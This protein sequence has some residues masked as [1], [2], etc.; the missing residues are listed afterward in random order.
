MS[1]GRDNTKKVIRRR[2]ILTLVLLSVYMVSMFAP[3]VASADT[4]GILIPVSQTFTN[5]GM[6]VEPTS[7]FEYRLAPELAWYPMPAYSEGAIYDFSLT[8]NDSTEIGPIDFS[9]V[10][11]GIYTYHVMCTSPLAPYYTLDQQVFT[12]MV[13]VMHGQI[14]IVVAYQENGNK[15]SDIRFDHEYDYGGD[16]IPVTTQDPPVKKTVSGDRPKTASLF[17]F[18]LRAEDT[19]NPMPAGSKDGVKLI[20]IEGTGQTEFGSWTYAEQGVYHYTIKELNTGVSGYT[21]DKT[22]Y[23]ITDTVTALSDGRLVIDRSITDDT[24]R[25]ATDFSFVNV[26]EAPILPNPFNPDGGVRTGDL[27]NPVLWAAVALASVGFLII[28]LHHRKDKD[29]TVS[30]SS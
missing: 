27:N 3:L 24:H 10:D 11:V 14:S 8:G 29:Q 22:I 9:Q 16:Y 18:E 21:Y 20:E 23:T 25:E 17:T 13:Y 4:E 7:T 2:T 1:R 12:I 15:V 19:S 6:V 5:T 26:F 28:V 30:S